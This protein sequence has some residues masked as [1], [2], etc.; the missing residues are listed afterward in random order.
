VDCAWQLIYDRA[1]AFGAE[2]QLLGVHAPQDWSNALDGGPRR[3]VR[4]DQ[5][6]DDLRQGNR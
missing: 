1:H 6:I 4:A 3:L 5:S 2:E